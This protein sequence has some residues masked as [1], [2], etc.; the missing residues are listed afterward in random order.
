MKHFYVNLILFL[1][2]VFIYVTHV[3]THRL[4]HVDQ[5][6]QYYKMDRSGW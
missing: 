2:S 4:V 5:L 1:Q 6:T 3:C